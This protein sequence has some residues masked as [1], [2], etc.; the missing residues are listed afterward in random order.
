MPS[1]RSDFGHPDVA[2][3]LTCLS[4]Y[5]GGLTPSQVREC[6]DLLFKLDNPTLEYEKWVER[7][8]KKI[9]VSFCQLIGVNTKDV[10]TFTDDVVPM[11][12]HNQA[13]IDF[14]LSHVVFPK[15][16][17]EFLFK[18]GTSGWDLAKDKANFT[19]GFSGT[20]DNSDLLPTS[21]SQSDPVNQLRM[22][23]QVLGYLLRPENG[24]YICTQVE[25]TERQP[26]S[27]EE[28]LGLLVC[29]PK[30]IRVLLDVGAQV[31][32]YFP[33]SNN[34][35]TAMLDAGN[36]EQATGREMVIVKAECCS[37]RVLR[38]C[39]YIVG[40]KSRWCC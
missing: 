6:F 19:T 23:A 10:Q 17:K 28:F 21:I 29:E 33:E 11:F 30:E 12:Q 22:N 35:S 34:I 32:L 24:R 4:Y 20:N 14:F 13:I 36:D 5:Y 40:S 3:C 8:G 37:R 18:L 2:V 9:P 38:R 31:S 39:G 16:A 26:C 15:E 27:V 1:L 7:G 25:G